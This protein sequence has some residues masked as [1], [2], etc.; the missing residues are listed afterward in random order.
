[1]KSRQWKR[2][3]ALFCAF[4][5]ILSLSPAI[6]AAGTPASSRNINKQ[7]Y[8]TY[9]NTVKSYLYP[10][11]QKGLTRVEYLDGKVVVEDYDS[12][13]R[14]TAGRRLQ[15][16][17]P[18]WGGFFAGGDANYLI[19]G[20]ENPGESASAEVIRV[21][22]YSKDW[23]RQGETVIKGADVR[24]PFAGGSV[25][26]AEE[27]GYLYIHCA[28]K[29]VKNRHTMY[30]P[31]N[32]GVNHQANLFLEIRESDM[33][34]VDSYDQ[35][36]NLDFGYVSH[37]FNEFVLIDSEKNI[38]TL[39]HSDSDSSA[40]GRKNHG[41]AKDVKARGA[42][43]IRY[44]EKAGQ[45]HFK[46]KD[47]FQWCEYSLVQ[48]FG[49]AS[50]NNNTGA[51]LGGF[52]ETAGGYV[53]AFSYDGKGGSG[54]RN[55]YLGYTAK[56]GLTSA[57]KKISAASGVTTPQMVSTGLSGGYILWNGKSGSTANDTL[58]YAAYSD[59]GG[60]GSVQTAKASLSDCQPVLFGGKAVWYVTNNSAPVFYGLDA[61][62]VKVLGGAG[63]GETP[64]DPA[65]PEKPAV[66][67]KPSSGELTVDVMLAPSTFSAYAA[68]TSD[69]T[70]YSWDYGAEKLVKLGSG[71][72]AAGNRWGIKA[73]HSLWTWNYDS[74]VPEKVM[75][76]AYT[77]DF[78]SDVYCVLKTDGTL[79]GTDFTDPEHFKKMDSGVKQAFVEDTEGMGLCYT[80]SKNGDFS[81]RVVPDTDSSVWMSGITAFSAGFNNSL[82]LKDGS[83]YYFGFATY[84]EYIPME[85]PRKVMDGAVCFDAESRSVVTSDGT[86][87]GLEL[88]SGAHKKLMSDVV[89]VRGSMAL[90]RDGTLWNIELDSFSLERSEPKK[91]LDNVRLPDVIAKSAGT[92]AR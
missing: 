35:T 60:V 27:G 15:A 74:T 85:S 44:D 52:E 64:A 8:V 58:Y 20:K 10:N 61:S 69:G 49:G 9:G 28:R 45:D 91:V 55:I 12:S 36:W 18:I 23:K 38:V 48:G 79:W 34:L 50:G 70:L 24:V 16:E 33:K 25:R 73:D 6:S 42:V 11:G 46:G 39:S 62:G 31:M 41:Y 26:C 29:M 7:D 56:K 84:G 89:A 75:D 57:S 17:L 82:Y 19:F 78:G 21:V 1:M 22:K 80:V 30:G 37:A 83:L 2:L 92:S 87:Y 77:A 67:D 43:L 88:Q 4:A 51:S 32:D 90:K 65:T 47:Q 13:F 14:L 76:G 59:G 54:A 71:Y 86:L 72:I 53:S 81:C 68:V 63:Q 40:N 3:T 66:P 5:L